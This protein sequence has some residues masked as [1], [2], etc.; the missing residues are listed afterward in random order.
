MI[1]RIIVINT[2]SNN[3]TLIEDYEQS[4]ETKLIHIAWRKL[5]YICILN[6]FQKLRININ[7]FF[8]AQFPVL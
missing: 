2:N 7:K 1:R 5:T 8:P 4:E 6:T 3:Y